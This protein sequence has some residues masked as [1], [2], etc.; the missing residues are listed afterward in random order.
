MRTTA[1]IR[2]DPEDAHLLTAYRWQVHKYG[3]D[4]WYVSARLATGTLYLHRLIMGC[5]KGDGLEVDHW[6]GDGLNNRRSNLRVVTHAVNLRNQRLSIANTSGYTGV[7]KARKRWIAQT[8][9]KG[10]KV[11]LGTFDTPKAAH[12]ARQAFEQSLIAN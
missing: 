10:K 2:I 1:D 6:D 8:K 11:H 7:S 5:T 3:R 9:V 12:E 4:K